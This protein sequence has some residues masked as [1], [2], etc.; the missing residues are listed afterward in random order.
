MWKDGKRV[1]FLALWLI[2]SLVSL[3]SQTARWTS[4]EGQINGKIKSFTLFD[5]LF[6]D[7]SGTW[8]E[9]HKFKVITQNYDQNGRIIET[10]IYNVDGSVKSIG[11]NTYDNKGNKIEESGYTAS[12]VLLFKTTYVYDKNGAVLT[13]SIFNSQNTLLDK[14]RYSYDDKGNILEEK[15]YNGDGTLRCILVRSYDNSGNLRE[16]SE[17]RPDGALVLSTRCQYDNRGCLKEKSEITPNETILS[18]KIY[19]LDASTNISEIDCQNKSGASEY[20][21]NFT[22]D[23]KNN[24]TKKIRS[25]PVKVSGK[26]TYNPYAGEYR[27]IEYF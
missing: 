27:T 3:N 26:T 2:G 11:K 19:S 8:V 15:Q 14:S 24:W 5:V 12:N 1:I 9:L 21:I 7:N 4:D 25:K 16:T 10:I 13:K 23:E 17:F 6:A 22:Y 18:R 20:K